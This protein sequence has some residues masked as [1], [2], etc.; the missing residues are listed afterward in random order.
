MVLKFFDIHYILL[1]FL[2]TYMHLAN[3]HFM[4]SWTWSSGSWI[5]DYLCNLCLSPL[6]LWVG[7]PLRRGI[8]DKTLCDKVCQRLATGRWFSPGTPVSSTNKTDHQ[9]IAQILLKVA[10]STITSYISISGRALA[11]TWNNW[12][13]KHLIS[14]FCK[15]PGRL[16]DHYFF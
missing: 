6:K 2:E 14:N 7:I 13:L 3:I 15:F 9:D 4:P 16:P 11:A 5:Y 12:I 1:F 8:L 10:L